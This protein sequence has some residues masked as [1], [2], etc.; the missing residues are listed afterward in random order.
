[1]IPGAEHAHVV[2]LDLRTGRQ[3]VATAD[4]ARALADVIRYTADQRVPHGMCEPIVT[5]EPSEYGGTH[6]CAVVRR[7]SCEDPMDQREIWRLA[8]ADL[9]DDP[10]G[11]TTA[12]MVEPM[13]GAWALWAAWTVDGAGDDCSELWIEAADNVAHA[14]AALCTH[15]WGPT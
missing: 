12:I 3:R 4:E 15:V 9:L 10:A 1:M 6:P 2:A 13:P 14:T 5:T 11:A 8:A 7:L